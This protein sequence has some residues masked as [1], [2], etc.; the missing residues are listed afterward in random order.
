MTDE[1]RRRSVAISDEEY[2]KVVR[3]AARLQATKGEPISV[4]E[5]IRDAVRQRLAREARK[6]ER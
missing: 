6:V 2:A 5:W 4:A 3:A 1:M